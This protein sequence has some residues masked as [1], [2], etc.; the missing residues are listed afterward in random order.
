MSSAK[1]QPRPRDAPKLILPTVAEIIAAIAERSDSLEDTKWTVGSEQGHYH[2]G[3]K[4]KGKSFTGNFWYALIN[5]NSYLVANTNN[6][7]GIINSAIDV[8]NE[9]F[10]DDYERAVNDPSAVGIGEYLSELKDFILDNDMMW[11]QQCV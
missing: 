6:G 8:V 5:V 4:I 11:M 2:E 10:N 3:A 9:T 1:S 7:A